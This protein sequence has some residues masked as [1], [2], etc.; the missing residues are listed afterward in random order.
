[1]LLVFDVGNTNTVLGALAGDQVVER[2]RVTT[3]PRTT[4]EMG[5]LLQLLGADLSAN[6]VSGVLS[7]VVPTV[8]YAIE[9]ASRR[10]LKVDGHGRE[11]EPVCGFG[12]T[13]QRGGGGPYC[14]LRGCL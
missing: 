5:L 11:L 14:Q 1:M 4:D 3:K 13:T 2:W 6:D 8:L 7:C 12:Q 9:K 10:Y